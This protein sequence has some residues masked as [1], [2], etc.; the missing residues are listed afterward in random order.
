MNATL[1]A[2]LSPVLALSLLVAP[3]VLAVEEPVAALGG[4]DPVLLTQGMEV[5]GKAGR[6]VTRGRYRYLFCDAEN[7]R[8]FEAAP[9][10]YGIQFD[11][12]C[13]KMGPLSGRGSPKRWFV[14]EGRIY[15]F[16]SEGCRDSFKSDPSAYTDRADAPPTGTDAA[17]QRGRELIELALAGFGGADKV[18]ALKNVRWETI[19]IYEQEGK[20]TEMR[21][22]M[23]VV[24]PDQLR[25]DYAYGDFR[26]GH[27]LADGK[28]VEVNA[29]NEATPL[30]AE[31]YEFVNRRLFREPLALLRARGQPGFVAFAAGAGEIN[32][33]PVEWLNVG[34][35]GATTRL[36]ID[37][38]TGHILAAVYRGRAPSSMGEIC[39]TYSDFKTMEG[40]LTLPQ[41]WNVSYDGQP[42]AGGN[43]VSRSVALNVPVASR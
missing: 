16:A 23:T 20:Q 36:G 43:P 41:Q 29:E 40:G 19:T 8:K 7:Q 30:P 17:Q 3:V 21:Q 22:G 28:L 34:Y 15:L 27:E 25:L 31:V 1:S 38:K 4:L 12:F 5:V 37:P 18:D 10:Q 42:S 9:D 2:K 14:S 24:L 33:H 39:R 6:Q 13:M 32:G 11:G 26:E 35:A